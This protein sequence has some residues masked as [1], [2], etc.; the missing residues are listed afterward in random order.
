M[1]EAEKSIF[2]IS[3]RRVRHDLQPIQQVLSEVYDRVDQLSRR[4]D[5]IFGVPTGLI[6][7]DRLLG[8]AAEIGPADH[9]RAPGHG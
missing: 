9:R 6:D 2:S 3:E 8:R 5:E 4:D 7:L 1:D